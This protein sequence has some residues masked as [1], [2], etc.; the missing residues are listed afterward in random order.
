MLVLVGHTPSDNGS[1]TSVDTCESQAVSSDRALAGLD[2][3][4]VG[5]VA[6]PPSVPPTLLSHCLMAAAAP[7]DHVARTACG[8]G[9]TG[10]A[11]TVPVQCPSAGRGGCAGA[12]CVRTSALV[13]AARQASQ[14]LHVQCVMAVPMQLPATIV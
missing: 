4:G 3:V 2:F 8:G 14:G 12:V 7:F 13:A 5:L 6:G 11:I 10:W 1:G 9:F